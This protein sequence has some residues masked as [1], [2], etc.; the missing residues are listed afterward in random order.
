M[1]AG[2][3]SAAIE[4]CHSRAPAIARELS[5]RYSVDAHRTSLK[6]RATPPQDWENDVLKDFDARRAKGEDPSGI[7]FHEVVTLEGKP[8]LRFMKAIGTLPV[9]LS[10][11][12][13][14]VAPEIKAKLDTLYS[15]DMAIGYKAGE[16]RGAFSITSPL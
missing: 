14:N 5:E 13:E 2:G 12:G 11:H 10:C 6:P 8:H 16:L 1:K 15:N 9:C 3:P 7:E 4:V